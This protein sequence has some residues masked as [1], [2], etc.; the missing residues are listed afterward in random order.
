MDF[1]VAWLNQKFQVPWEY[2]FAALTGVG[3]R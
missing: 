2:K 1:R 3:K